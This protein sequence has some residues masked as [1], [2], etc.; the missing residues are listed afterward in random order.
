MNNRSLQLIV[1]LVVL[2]CALHDLNFGVVLIG[3]IVC[4]VRYSAFNSVVLHPLTGRSSL[5]RDLYTQLAKWEYQDDGSHHADA[6]HIGAQDDRLGAQDDSTPRCPVSQILSGRQRPGIVNTRQPE[7]AP[8]RDSDEMSV[9]SDLAILQ[10][11]ELN[12]TELEAIFG[13]AGGASAT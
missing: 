6:R 11:L 13:G 5:A 7:E 2:Y 10:D 3:V 4:A 8:P 12:D 9:A 1:A